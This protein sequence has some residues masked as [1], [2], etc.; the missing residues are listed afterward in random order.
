MCYV[1]TYS[2]AGSIPPDSGRILDSGGFWNALILPQNDCIRTCPTG[3]RPESSGIWQIT[4]NQIQPEQ[5]QKLECTSKVYR[6]YVNV[7]VDKKGTLVVYV[8][9]KKQKALHGLMRASLL[10]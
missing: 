4:E 5:N 10:S 7:M 2:I 1:V 8:K 6:K 3:S 9:L